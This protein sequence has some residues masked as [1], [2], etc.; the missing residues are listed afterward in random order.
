M[1]A[2]RGSPADQAEQARLQLALPNLWER[3]CSRR[4]TEQSRHLFRPKH[5]FREQ[6]R[7]H[8][9]HLYPKT[10]SLSLWA[11]LAPPQSMRLVP[12]V[13]HAHFNQQ[14][15]VQL[16]RAAHV[17]ANLCA[18]LLNQIFANFQHQFIVHLQDDPSI[19]P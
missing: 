18:D 12:I 2:K 3:A 14:R 1:V 17:L 4:G 10:G 9:D 15:D 16:C 8:R 19:Q 5:R 7:S 6:A 13:A 11:E